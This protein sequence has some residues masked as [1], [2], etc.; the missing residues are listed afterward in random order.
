V[1]KQSTSVLKKT[2]DVD[3]EYSSF[4]NNALVSEDLVRCLRYNCPLVKPQNKRSSSDLKVMFNEPIGING[5][6]N[7]L[8]S[9]P[10]TARFVFLRN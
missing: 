4:L 6:N 5:E 9:S 2:S 7:P 10:D 3:I 8:Y 1:V